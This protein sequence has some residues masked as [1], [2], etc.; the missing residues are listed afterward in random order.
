MDEEKSGREHEGGELPVPS[1]PPHRLP[2]LVTDPLR[3]S[4]PVNDPPSL[5]TTNTTVK[6]ALFS[7][8]PLIHPPSNTTTDAFST[9][10]PLVAEDL[11][12]LSQIAKDPTRKLWPLAFDPSRISQD[13]GEPVNQ[14]SVTTD[15]T[16]FPTVKLGNGVGSNH[17]P[18]GGVD[19]HNPTANGGIP[20]KSSLGVKIGGSDEELDDN[21]DIMRET[22]VIPP[23]GGW[24]WVVVF[25]S[26]MCNVMVDG[27][28]F[29]T[30]LLLP[31]IVK[32]FDVSYSQVSWVSSL[33]GGF[34]LLAGPFVASLANAFGFRAV[35]I[36]GSLVA[37][38]A[39]GVSYFATNIY[40]LYFSYGVV[41]GIGFGFIYVPAV[42]AT[43]FYFEKRRALATGMAVCGSGIGTFV[44]SP[45]I[46][47]IVRSSGWRVVLLVNG[48]LIL[49][50]MIYGLAFR[51]LSPTTGKVIAVEEDPPH[52]TPLLLRIKMARDAQLKAC[53]S[54][55]SL[56]S[57][58][59]SRPYAEHSDKPLMNP[60]VARL[61]LDD[62]MKR[63]SCTGI[64]KDQI[65]DGVPRRCSLA[66]LRSESARPFYRDDIFYSGSLAR[67]PQYTSSESV[68]QYHMS[69]TNIPVG[70]IMEEDEYE[71][72]KRSCCNPVAAKS[73]LSK[74]FDVSLCTSP[75]FIVLSLAGFLSLLSLFVPFNFLPIFVTS[76]QEA[77][78]LSDD[79]VEP[80]IAFLMSLI[81]ICNTIG[82]VVCGWISD[83]P[84]VDAILV[85]NVGLF[86]GGVATCLLPFI[87]NVSLLY[88]YA[89][90][91][92]VSVAI[93]ASLR[94][95]LLVELLGLEKLTN[96]FGLL[97]LIQGVAASFGSPIAGGFADLTGG[98]STS[99]FVF[100]ALYAISGLMCIPIRRIKQWEL[101][102]V[103]LQEK[104]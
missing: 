38:A 28:I 32:E 17:L 101:N 26:F 66:S 56:Q 29:T 72:G 53:M 52:G 73:V 36:I 77:L 8:D 50:C 71:E 2:P 25:A 96:A 22:R 99:F 27:I 60:N 24:G 86:V 15:L 81:G 34:Y 46:S 1:G 9:A 65:A 83:H 42:I 98:F 64:T 95:I 89:I 44:L 100:G 45:I 63:N 97:L 20:E 69:V 68:D 7:S 79:E 49:S 6:Q 91:F 57:R 85:N 58:S 40:F 13:G 103:K 33:L 43:G 31:A 41:G 104:I 84:K 102:R 11:P 61:M 48:G 21:C 3:P 14:T 88:G 51:P 55:V 4:S 37:G 62:P 92:G 67:L 18:N 80:T 23:D 35:C 47:S 76:R 93:F 70:A 94:S 16:K 78:G 12:K 54:D 19:L 5:P 75:T 90:V 74:M 82:R 87:N 30:G 39:C 10:T 59:G